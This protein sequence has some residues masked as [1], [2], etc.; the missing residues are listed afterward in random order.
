ME[1]GRKLGNGLSQPFLIL[2]G[3]PSP[4]GRHGEGTSC[5]M[6]IWLPSLPS[7]RFSFGSPPRGR[8]RR[9]VATLAK[10][11]IRSLRARSMD[12]VKAPARGE[13][14]KGPENL[15]RIKRIRVCAQLP[16]AARR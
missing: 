2:S 14:M 4:T 12:T 1:I 8:G 11:I 10:S 16:L 9:A 7:P 6:W 5:I 3:E 13:H 15:D